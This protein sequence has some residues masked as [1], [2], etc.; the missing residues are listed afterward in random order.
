[1]TSIF[2]GTQPHKTR[3]KLQPKQGSFGF[4]VYIR[5]Y[6]IICIYILAVSIP[7][8]ILNKT[9]ECGLF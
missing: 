8:M 2:E 4:Q 7:K 5:I 1:M 3:P 9:T 6:I